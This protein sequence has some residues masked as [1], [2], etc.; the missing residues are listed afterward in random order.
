MSRKPR[1]DKR[2]ESNHRTDC[3]WRG[4]LERL[5]DGSVRAALTAEHERGLLVV[6][7]V[8]D[9]EAGGYQLQASLYREGHLEVAGLKELLP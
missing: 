3:V 5:A 2:G 9:A 6:V 8:R 1:T 4:H 7:G